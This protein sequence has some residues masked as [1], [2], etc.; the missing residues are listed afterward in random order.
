MSVSHASPLP[1]APWW[2]FPLVWMVIAGPAIVVVAG[3]VTLWIA[4]RSPN[5]IVSDNAYR[6]GRETRSTPVDKTLMPALAGR[7]HAA[8]P[9]DDVPVTKP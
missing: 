2:K 5:P 3:F 7:N 6:Q 1:G 8:T 9:G 4:L